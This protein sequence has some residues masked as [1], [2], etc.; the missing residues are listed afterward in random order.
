MNLLSNIKS[1]I[2]NFI[3]KRYLPLVP[4][5]LSFIPYTLSLILITL[6][7]CTDDKLINPDSSSSSS[8]VDGDA[9]SIYFDP[10]ADFSARASFHSDAEQNEN[11]IR[12]FRVKFFISDPDGSGNDY[13]LFDSPIISSFEKIY[14]EA[15]N[16]LY[17]TTIQIGNLTD[18]NGNKLAGKIRELLR[19]YPFKIAI[20]ANMPNEGRTSWFG[21]TN[22]KMTNEFSYSYLCNTSDL[23]VVKTIN[24][25]HF[26]QK[27][28]TYGK[29]KYK[30]L[31]KQYGSDYYVSDNVG[32]MNRRST[33]DEYH[34]TT[35]KTP[36]SDLIENEAMAAN[37]IRNYW[38]PWWDYRYQNKQ[39][40]IKEAVYYD[41]E[42]L[43]QLWN[44]GGSVYDSNNELSFDQIWDG[45][46]KEWG[47]NWKLR[48]SNKFKESNDWFG[49]NEFWFTPNAYYSNDGL[50]IIQNENHP[51]TSDASTYVRI[52][53]SND[54]YGIILP[55]SDGIET[56]TSN[57]KTEQYLKYTVDEKYVPNSGA[58]GSISFIA[59][60]S[61]HLRVKYSSLNGS[62][63][64]IRIQRSSN[65]ISSDDSYFTSSITPVDLPGESMEI[66]IT[67]DP[68]PIFIYAPNDP[69]VIYAIEFIS[70]IYLN[71]T[72]RE[73]VPL[74][75][76]NAIAM[77]GVQE[78][79]AFGTWANGETKD[80][81]GKP[82]S[83]I[84]SV[85]KVVVNLPKEAKHIYL[86]CMNSSA[87]IEP[88]DLSTSTSETWTLKHQ[89]GEKDCEWFRIKDH[90]PWYKEEGGQT[91]DQ[92]KNWLSWYYGT[93]DSWK[94]DEE[95]GKIAVPNTNDYPN[96]FNPRIERSDF[97][98]FI[99]TGEVNG[100]HRYILYVPEKGVDDPND[101]GDDEEKR[102][103]NSSPKVIHIEYRY[104]ND[105]YSNNLDDN[106]CYRIYFTDYATNTAIKSLRPSEYES[107]EAN[108]DNLTQHWPIMRNHIYT[109]NV[110]HTESTL[111]NQ[112]ILVQI[113]PWDYKPQSDWEETW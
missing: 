28:N 26:L 59:Q 112:N 107:Y 40:G 41:Y 53:K 10:G 34:V 61:G 11:L 68:E 110:T 20:I 14:G 105:T 24:D 12:K 13:F 69:I 65:T 109:F 72:N 100:S 3:G 89:G 58:N 63:A 4:Y 95:W 2:R 18:N 73:G 48:N 111:V 42:N 90:E 19:S 60:N 25:L 49:W 35:G 54:R 98:E 84:R 57:G 52:T 91:E 15:G 44:F 37:W 22:E 43:W 39:D 113:K 76:T 86:R 23:S 17:K 46:C 75:G 94:E 70:D 66:K 45:S 97:C 77:V 85:A 82:V 7:S 78:Y 99:Y 9:I 103:V 62:S 31:A 51:N 74:N 6:L 33:T 5:T 104:D 87:N 64:K 106:N 81:K 21:D 67:G 83:L 101:Y 88:V 16:E 56:R 47:Y 102:N 29:K 71:D 108:H 27:D 32:W 8:E 79:D 30:F 93:W 1:S 80:L 36:S 55:K 96:I 38:D 92:Y 50:Y